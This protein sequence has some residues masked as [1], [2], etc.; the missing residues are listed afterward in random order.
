MRRILARRSNTS[1]WSSRGRS[2]HRMSPALAELELLEAAGD[3]IESVNIATSA[4]ITSS[5]TKDAPENAGALVDGKAT[6]WVSRDGATPA[7]FQL[8]YAK[9]REVD[10]VRLQVRGRPARPQ[11]A[12]HVEGDRRERRRTYGRRTNRSRPEQTAGHRD[13]RAGRHEHHTHPHGH[14]RRPHPLQR[15][16]RMAAGVRDRGLRDARQR[17]SRR[18][19]D[20][21]GRLDAHGC[22]PRQA[23]GRRPRQRGHLDG[24]G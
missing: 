8:D 15:L 18:Q 17:G 1:P 22:R 21:L 9:A 23:D 7:W 14:R 13:G 2:A 19:D 12:V 4:A 20:G 5:P 3:T 10:S 24:H 16:A 11:H 6:A